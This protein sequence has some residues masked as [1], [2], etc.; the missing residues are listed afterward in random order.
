MAASISNKLVKKALRCFQGLAVYLIACW[1]KLTN[2]INHCRYHLRYGGQPGWK[3]SGKALPWQ[4]C[5]LDCDLEHKAML[6]I[7]EGMNQTTV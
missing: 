7:N 2:K 1:V 5:D 4:A 6:I 3:V